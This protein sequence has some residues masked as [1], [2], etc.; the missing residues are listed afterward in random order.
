MSTRRL[1]E[2]LILNLDRST[3]HLLELHRAMAANRTAWVSMRPGVLDKALPALGDVA[4]RHDRLAAEREQLVGQI[5][6]VSGWQ[7]TVTISRIVRS[8]DHD[9]GRRLRRAADRARDAARKVGVE[10]R[11]GERL[12]QF[13]QEAHFGMFQSMNEEQTAGARS[14]GRDA[15]IVG[16]GPHRGSLVDHRY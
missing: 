11:L 4:G 5:A 13:S 14:Y 7:G 9:L 10:N 2:D 8:V 1:I 12:L 16:E 3:A 15:K 6:T